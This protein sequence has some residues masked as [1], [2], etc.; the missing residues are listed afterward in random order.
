MHTPLI[1]ALTTIAR[2]HIAS[3]RP[4]SAPPMPS[5]PRPPRPSAGADPDARVAIVGA[6]LA[7]MTAA[8][9]LSD[10][11]RSFS[12]YEA[13]ARVGGRVF[14]DRDYFEEGQEFEWYGELIDTGHTTM[15]DLAT[16]FGLEV[17]Y[18][19]AA[20]LPGATD[21]Y[22][23]H[24][25]YYPV[26]DAHADFAA[27][28]PRLT[29][30]RE[31]AGYP[32]L[33][34]RS[35]AAGREL[36]GMSVHDWIASRVPGGHRSPLGALLDTAMWIEL[37][38]DTRHQSALN[39][40]YLLA[41]QQDPRHFELFGA[42]DEVFR[43]RG[44]NQQVPERIATRVGREHLHFG[45][46]LQRI[47][48][49]AGGT[50]DLTFAVGSQPPRIVNTDHVVLALPFAVLRGLDY[51][52]AGFDQRKRAAIQELGRGRQSKQHLQF[53]R[54]VWIESG[55]KPAHGTGTSYSDTGYQVTWEASRCQAGTQGIL[56]GYTGGSRVDAMHTTTAFAT[57][58]NPDVVR[59]ACRF[60]AQV[61]PVFPGLTAAW[62]GKA[63][64][65][66]PHLDPHFLCSYSYYRVG[67][68]QRFAGYEGER[69]G[70]VH[71]A[72]EHTSVDFQG[73]MEGAAREG[74]RA[75][76]EIVPVGVPQ[77]TDAVGRARY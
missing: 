6:G 73:F 62:T 77:S 67:Q 24:G 39:L 8:L 45:W 15:R 57:A 44:G 4:G 31:A 10:A 3:L 63:T 59:D 51:E 74:V 16:R 64:Q 7:G 43:I 20:D 1:R 17:D 76:R 66:L 49:A 25:E 41:D 2:R 26:E 75:A 30:D 55:T 36:D 5:A 48:Q 65:G 28:W 42:S 56:V 9:T 69:Q 23:F 37:N 29:A 33:W 52:D 53:E 54:R 60:L 35:T 40:V 61:E 68:H 58:E 27:L 32:T 18:L 72:G 47:A 11:G 12:V 50:I 70:N 19:P 71:F 21:T 14:S 34:D 13:S 46:K 22:H 38:A